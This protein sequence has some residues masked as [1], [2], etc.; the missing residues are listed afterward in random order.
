MKSSNWQ[1][2]EDIK[3][4][5]VET[6]ET[7]GD[8]FALYRTLTTG[9]LTLLSDALTSLTLSCFD[10]FDG[11]QSA[12]QVRLRADVA[13]AQR[14]SQAG[15]C[16]CQC[17]ALQSSLFMHRNDSG[18]VLGVFVPRAQL[19][20]LLQGSRLLRRRGQAVPQEQAAEVVPRSL[21]PR[22]RPR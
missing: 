20:P 21:V 13:D 18:Q 6:Y 22:L 11:W 7:L 1:E 15:P 8:V 17:L 5:T 14:R 9:P 19:L 2:I 4:A 3:T 10:R 16:L 12:G